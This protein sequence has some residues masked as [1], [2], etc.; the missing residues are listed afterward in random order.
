MRYLFFLLT[1]ICLQVS[2]QRQT[3]STSLLTKS[4]IQ[5]LI[6]GA[7]GGTVSS[8][9]GTTNK[10]VIT[11]TPTVAPVINVGSDIVDKTAAT[12][13]SAGA[14]QSFTSSAATAAINLVG[15][16]T[17]TSDP[18]SLV[19][20]DVW[21]VGAPSSVIKYR[22]ASSGLTKELT[23]ND[24]TQTLT[25]KTIAGATNN[26][27][28][29]LLNVRVLT[30]G[31]TYTPTTGTTKVILYL[32]GGGGGGGGASGAA[33]S[34]GA[35]GGGGGGGLAI[36]YIN[37]VSGTYTYAIGAGGTAG[38]NTGGNGGAGGNTTFANGATT[39]TAFGGAGG[40]GQVTGTAAAFVLGGAGAA[41]S[42]NGDLNAG[43][44]PGIM[45]YRVS[46]TLGY[47]GT[48]GDSEYGGAG[49][50]LTTAGAG[51][52]ATGFGSGGGGALST[53]N[54]ARA[55]GTGAPGAIIAIEYR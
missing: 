54:T 16:S 23:T 15:A 20:G 13:F 6:S 52:N 8:V 41:V 25:N 7:G 1:L 10:I 43:G 26:V 21:M 14:K 45:A 38:A 17:I 42:T 51:S 9:T 18:S 36:K 24:A 47:S 39:I 49:Q 11:G 22:E 34:V 12:T 44:S 27:E 55:G 28:G 33:S 53:A 40:I 30:S 4:E 32:I 46:G 19:G 5:A 50:G 29:T 48:G 31:T 37:N 2:A 3:A 35:A